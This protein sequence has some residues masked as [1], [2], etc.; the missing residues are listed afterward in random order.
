MRTALFWV[1]FVTLRHM[2]LKFQTLMRSLLNYSYEV[3][4][5]IA[6]KPSGGK[7]ESVRKRE[8]IEDGYGEDALQLS[9]S[10]IAQYLV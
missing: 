10:L 6:Q 5:C 3:F 8:R 7:L 9:I 2:D 1:H 4:E